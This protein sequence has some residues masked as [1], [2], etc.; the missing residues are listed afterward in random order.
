MTFFVK[1]SSSAD[2]YTFMRIMITP[3]ASA[4]IYKNS[5]APDI[6][7]LVGDA[8]NFEK[9]LSYRKHLAVAKLHPYV[10]P[11]KYLRSGAFGLCHYVADKMILLFCPPQ[12]TNLM[13]DEFFEK[14]LALDSA[15]ICL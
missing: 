1:Q 5:T 13:H 11:V 14:H 8:M 10:K 15:T 3:E 7:G 2:R 4:I 9:T 6:L 12:N